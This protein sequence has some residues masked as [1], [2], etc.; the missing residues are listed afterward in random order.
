MSTSADETL[1]RASRRDVLKAGAALTIAFW[2][3]QRGAVAAEAPTSAVLEPNAFV[4]IGDDDTVT[5]ISKHVEMGQGSYT[6]LATLIAEELDADWKQVSVE[7]APADAKLYN[8]LSFGPMQGTGGSSSLSNSFDQLRSAG[9]TARALL[10]SAAAQRWSVPA[11]E[12]AITAGVVSHS[13]SNRTARFGELVGDAVKLPVPTDAK[14]K[15]PANYTLIGK[16]LTRVDSRAKSTGT[17]TFTQDIQLPGMLTALVLHP[18]RFGA[19]VKSFDASK[20]QAIKG[21]KTVVAFETPVRAGIAV[22]ATDF[23]TARKARDLVTVQWDESKAF[24]SGSA[25]LLARYRELAAKPGASAKRVGDADA[26]L[27]SAAQVVEATYEFPYLAHASMEPL[28]CVVRVGAQECEI[29]NGDQ[30]QTPDQ[31]AVAKL[32]GIPPAAVKINMLYAGG[33]FGRRANPQSDYVVEAVAIAKAANVREPVKMVWTREEDMRAG[34]YRPLYVH[35]LKA[36]LD[37]DG[38]LIAWQ[39]RIAGQSILSGSP[40]AAPG[41]IDPTSVEGA[42]TLPY[43]I[44]NLSVELHTTHNPVPV[45]WWRSVGSTHTAFSTECFLDEIARLTHKD[46]YALRRELLADKH[47]R[48]RAVLDLVAEK[49]GWRNPRSQDQIWGLALHESFNSVVAQVAQLQ[50]TSDGLKLTKVI[51][52]VDCGLAVNPNIV[53]MQMESGIGYGLGAALSGAITIRDG[54]VE[55]GNFDDYPVLRINQMPAIEVH[56]VPASGKPTGV[57]EPGTPVIAPALANALALANGKPVRTLPLSS[58]AI[59]LA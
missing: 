5:V 33:S 46:P 28:N 4:R 1:I 14:P 13:K 54:Q 27:V 53:A 34:Y 19:K 17:A 30:F 10:V 48:H 42:S 38:R 58:Q 31:L 9:A 37:K 41:P 6:G 21:V 8:N 20:A 49:S 29:W 24:R 40:F 12:I 55:Q 16:N 18:P 2:L 36:G 56:I 44:P 7:G 39:H 11:N 35:T 26:A 45:Q 25:E 32:L 47:P 3:P 57:G 15:D 59:T 50:R 52:A 23:W 51:C 43:Q 22:L